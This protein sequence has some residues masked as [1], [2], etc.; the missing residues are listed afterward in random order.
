MTHHVSVVVVADNVNKRLSVVRPSQLASDINLPA[1][2]AARRVTF[3]SKRFVGI[4]KSTSELSTLP[5]NSVRAS[6][7]MKTARLALYG[8]IVNLVLSI[9]CFKKSRIVQ[10]RKCTTSHTAPGMG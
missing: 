9:F 3:E 8:G 10:N 1:G 2:D 7:V 4:R 5:V 6:F